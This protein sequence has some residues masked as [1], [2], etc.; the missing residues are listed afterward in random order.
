MLLAV[1]VSVFLPADLRLLCSVESNNV[2]KCLMLCVQKAQYFVFKQ[3]LVLIIPILFFRLHYVTST[4]CGFCQGNMSWCFKV[5]GNSYHWIID[6]YEKLQLPVI[7]SIVQALQKEVEDRMKE[8]ERG[9]TAQKKQTRIRMKVARAEEQEA[10]K[11]WVKRQAVQHTY[12][13]ETSMQEEDEN[14][15]LVSAAR[16]ALGGSAETNNE[17]TLISGKTCKCGSNQHQRT[18]H[19][20]CPLNK[21]SNK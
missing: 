12:G 20:A 7:P 3:V 1:F 21:R 9:R 8:I 2:L 6:L 11:K 10:R 17:V 13:E 5:R 15:S 19:S 4:N 16:E 18:T 14:P